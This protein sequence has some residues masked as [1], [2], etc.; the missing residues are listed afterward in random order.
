MDYTWS[1]DED[2]AT[3]RC[4]SRYDSSVSAVSNSGSGE[5][6]FSFTPFDTNNHYI[7]NTPEEDFDIE[8]ISVNFLESDAK[9]ANVQQ[10]YSVILAELMNSEKQINGYSVTKIEETNDSVLLKV[11]SIESLPNNSTPEWQEIYQQHRPL[12]IQNSVATANSIFLAENDVLI[13]KESLQL[14]EISDLSTSSYMFSSERPEDTQLYSLLNV[15]SKSVLRSLSDHIKIEGASTTSIPGPKTD[16]LCQS[17]NEDVPGT[18][19]EASTVSHC[20]QGQDT[21]E[22]I[23]PI[24]PDSSES[25]A[26]EYAVE[27]TVSSNAEK[28]QATACSGK[29]EIGP[30]CTRV[31]IFAP[32]LDMSVPSKVRRKLSPREL[33]KGVVFE[34][35]TALRGV[36]N[37]RRLFMQVLSR[38]FD[39]PNLDYTNRTVIDRFFSRAINPL[40][41]E[42]LELT[43][44]SPVTSRLRR[45]QT[46]SQ[47]AVAK[48][49]SEVFVIPNLNA[50]EKNKKP[51]QAKQL[52]ELQDRFDAYRR[53]Q[54]KHNGAFLRR[55]SKMEKKLVKIEGKQ[56]KRLSTSRRHSMPNPIRTA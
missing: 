47:D 37:F 14:A 4:L 27:V 43:K 10:P 53:A 25:R 6:S 56:L 32:D 7:T 17:K 46:N 48:F 36:R 52:Q 13:Q 35:N 16:S 11:N 18:V 42:R 38:F 9:S 44:K 15:P 2:P 31:G 29:E 40:A 20:S 12:A 34:L 5:Y 23:E 50:I 41:N 39:V 51:T 26:F 54:R 45:R 24:R 33:L 8:S 3:G 30:F 19:S 49:D 28:S 1:Y 21:I 22:S 55:I